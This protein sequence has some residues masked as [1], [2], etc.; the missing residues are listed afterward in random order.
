MA[1][2]GVSREP[3]LLEN[4][5]GIRPRSAYLKVI[6]DFTRWNDQL[7]FGCDDSANKEFLNKRKVK[8]NMEGPGQ[9]NSNLWFTSPEKPDLLGPTTAEGAVWLSEEVN[10]GAASEPFLFAGW[11]VR[12]AWIKNEGKQPLSFTFEVDEKGNNE[13]KN[14]K[15]IS[16]PAGQINPRGV[17]FDRYR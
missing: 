2:S 13:W 17:C 12:S 8:G 9:S 7:V 14:L 6:G 16:V 11:D 10:A 15:S 3:S 1:C 5:A 4:S